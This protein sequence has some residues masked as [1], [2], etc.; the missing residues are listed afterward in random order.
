MTINVTSRLGEAV[1][2]R[3]KSLRDR[4]TAFTRQED[5]SI[6]PMTLTMLFLM[7]AVGGMGIDVM[8]H[9]EK[10][11]ALQQALDNSVLAAASLKQ[12]LD[13]ESVVRDYFAK[14]GLSQYLTSVDIEKGLNFRTVRAEVDA[15]A[16]PYFLKMLGVDEFRVK[17]VSSAEER[18]SNVEISLVLD[19][20]GSMSG[21]RINNLRPAARDFVDT[22]LTNSDPGKASISIVPYSAQVNLGPDLMAQFNVTPIHDR[23]YCVELPD[24]VFGSISLSRTRSFLHN[25]HFDPI[26]SYSTATPSNYSCAYSNSWDSK[27]ALK[28]SNYVMPINSSAAELKAR[29]NGLSVGGNTSIDLGV[30]WGALLLDPKARSVTTGLVARGA[31]ASQFSERPLDFD[32]RETIKVLVVMTDGEHTTEYKLRDGYRTGDS[33]IWHNSSTGVS[34]VYYDRSGTTQDYYLPATNRWVTS[35]PA[36]SE[37][38]TW[39][40]VFARFTVQSVAYNFYQ[41]PLGVNYSTKTSEMVEYIYSVKDSRLQKVC[42][43]AKSEGVVIYGIAFEAPTNGKTQIRNCASSDAHYYDASGLQI[44][45]VFQSIANQISDLRLT[46]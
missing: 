30:K 23:S 41:K 31:V 27:P 11:V 7:L 44:K 22:I 34:T 26:S 13:P 18:I 35:V 32:P 4:V 17:A 37:R 43:A 6:Y 15:D 45:T 8:R 21:S 5:G 39:Q 24:D 14:A 29:I 1:A 33:H 36:G 28:S 16:N 42:N 38:L 40:E 19:I 46:Q 2:M 3:A 12:Q 20:S 25:P 9:E 10:R